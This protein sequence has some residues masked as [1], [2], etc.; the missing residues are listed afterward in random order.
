MMKYFA[1]LKTEQG[2]SELPRN[3]CSLLGFDLLVLS[4]DQEYVGQ[5][6]DREML[7][8]ILGGKATFEVAGKRFEQVGG[9]PNVFAGKPHSVYMPPGVEVRVAAR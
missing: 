9:R 3:P 8:V 1:A 6:G 2:L 7:A 4:A 5:T